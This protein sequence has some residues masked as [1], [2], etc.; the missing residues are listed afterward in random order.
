MQTGLFAIVILLIVVL[1]TLFKCVRIVPQGQQ[2][3]VERLGKY[4]VTLNAG[5][6]ILIPYIDNVAYKL[7]TKDQMFDIP[8]QEV[9]TRDNAVVSVNAICFVKIA[10]PQK[11]AYGVENFEIATVNLGMTSLRATIGK[12]DL[13]ESL[14][15][16]DVIKG[17][18]LMAM[19]DQMTDWGLIMRSIEIQD[20]NPSASMQVAMEQQAAAERERKAIET[21]A[22]GNKRAAILEAEGVKQ[23]TILKA[24][25]EQEAATRQAAAAISL[26]EGTR[27]ANQ[28]LADSVSIAGGQS[29]LNYQL[30]ARYVDA[31]SALSTSNNSKIIAMPADLAASIGGLVNAGAALGSGSELAAQPPRHQ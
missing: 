23:S 25:A 13:D 20:I 7:S 19:A 31:L 15:S 29:A 21:R 24:E 16:R 5:L 3:I 4:R 11:A 18:L 14:S 1:V 17:E 22:A 28:L 27:Q 10:D 2:W 9:I 8:T 6:N 12:M 26:A 30:A